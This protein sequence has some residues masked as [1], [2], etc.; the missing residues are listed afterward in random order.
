MTIET[1]TANVQ[2]DDLLGTVAAD[3]SDNDDIRS[4]L[5]EEEYI[6][7]EEL[8]WGIEIYTGQIFLEEEKPLQ[9]TV[10]VGDESRSYMN[11]IKVDMSLEAFVSSFKRLH[12]MLSMNGELTGE[13]LEINDIRDLD[14]Q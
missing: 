8:V 2:Y 11:Q 6:D 12:V 10:Y 1:F 3:H 13:E 5:I 14:D 7:E 9:V 4:W